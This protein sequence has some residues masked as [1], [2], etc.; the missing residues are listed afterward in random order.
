MP[1]KPQPPRQGLAALRARALKLIHTRNSYALSASVLNHLASYLIDVPDTAHDVAAQRIL[2]LNLVV[3]RAVNE[4]GRQLIH[5]FG[6]LGN[7]SIFKAMKGNYE[8]MKSSPPLAPTL[9]WPTRMAVTRSTRQL[10]KV[11]MTRRAI[12]TASPPPALS[13]AQPPATY[14]STPRPSSS[15][16]LFRPSSYSFY[17]PTTRPI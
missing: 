11:T 2:V 10:G 17:S 4:H 1:H 16:Q 3:T 15:R 9:R 14:P 5:E 7:T 13:E 8:V 12:L 6:I